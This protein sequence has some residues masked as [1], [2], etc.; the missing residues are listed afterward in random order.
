MKEGQLC[1]M[2]K[3]PSSIV[4]R[5]IRAEEKPQSLPAPQT[6]F[7]P[8]R[9]QEECLISVGSQPGQISRKSFCFAF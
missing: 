8:Q 1:Q 4:L 9:A 6:L 7:K 2:D 5:P 3:G